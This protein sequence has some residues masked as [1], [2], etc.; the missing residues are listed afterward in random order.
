[1]AELSDRKRISVDIYGTTYKL[2]G[3][4]AEYI[5]QIALLVDERMKLISENHSRL[6]LS[7][8]AV[9]AAVHTAEEMF[10]SQQE[11]IRVQN[12]NAKENKDLNKKLDELSDQLKSQQQ[13][14]NAQLQAQRKEIEQAARLELKEAHE[15]AKKQLKRVQDE[16]AL[17]L[18]SAKEVASNSYVQLQS[19]F[20]VALKQQQ[21]EHEMEQA[22]V[23]E[24]FHHQLEQLQA[25]AKSELEHERQQSLE[26]IQAIEEKWLLQLLEKEVDYEQKLKAQTDEK[27]EHL[28]KAIDHFKQEIS[29]EQKKRVQSESILQQTKVN[30]QRLTE[31]YDQAVERKTAITAQLCKLQEQYDVLM[32]KQNDADIVVQKSKSEQQRLHD[33]LLH[34]EQ[35]VK[36]LEDKVTVAVSNERS[37]QDIAEQRKVEIT[38]L[39]KQVAEITDQNKTLKVTIENVQAKL[40]TIQQENIEQQSKLLELDLGSE[41]LHQQLHDMS[42]KYNGAMER[43]A[44]NELKNIHLMKEKEKLEKKMFEL[45]EQRAVWQAKLEQM[46]EKEKQWQ[47]KE[48]EWQK[49][50]QEWS[51]RWDNLENELLAAQLQT[52]AGIQQMDTLQ[53]ETLRWNDERKETFEQNNQMQVKLRQSDERYDQI[54]R[55]LALLQDEYTKLQ[56]EYNEWLELIEDEI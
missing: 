2:V 34:A 1:M 36:K 15:E 27:D 38:Q 17:Q 33:M 28:N 55:E 24:Q 39:Q 37:W 46:D 43:E 54:V 51:D 49:Q 45:V 6:D 10:K 18:Q 40:Q 35:T 3:T 32:E 30:L 53:Q 4:S 20:D 52:A 41:Q 23:R 12:N 25:Q 8:I 5:K 16:A 19:Q 42:Q 31:E 21:E 47:Q 56:T 29:V 7:R 50:Q 14:W 9:L 13:H 11:L 22:K 48:R 26:E 44:E